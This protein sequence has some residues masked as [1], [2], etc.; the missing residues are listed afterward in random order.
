MVKFNI[1]FVILE[2]GNENLTSGKTRMG[3]GWTD[4]Q[5]IN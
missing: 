3:F 2:N 4:N 1:V 5:K